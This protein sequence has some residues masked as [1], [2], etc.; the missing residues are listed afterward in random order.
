MQRHFPNYDFVRALKKD[1]EAD[2]GSVFRYATH[3][4]TYLLMIER[5][6]LDDDSDIPDRD[7]LIEFIQS[8][9]VVKEKSAVRRMGERCIIDLLDVVKKYYY[10]PAMKGSNSISVVLI[11]SSA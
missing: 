5:Q 6:L 3:E 1:L 10:H 11:I 2:S 7:E 8:I 9:T 4:N